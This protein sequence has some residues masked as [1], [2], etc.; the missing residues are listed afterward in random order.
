MQRGLHDRGH[1]RRRPTAR[2]IPRLPSCSWLGC[3]SALGVPEDLGPSD[4]VQRTLLTALTRSATSSAARPKPSSSPGSGRSWPTPRPPPPSAHA[5]GDRGATG[6]SRSRRPWSNPRRVS[7]P[8]WRRTGPRRAGG[9][10]RSGAPARPGRGRW[11]KLPEDQRVAVELRY[12][13]GL[14]VPEIADQMGRTTVSVTGLLYRG[15]KALREGM[16]GPTE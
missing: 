8:G 1:R 10:L 5:R 13:K 6:C 9:S 12:L 2:A 15:T 16:T 14:S 4:L 7:T 11:P 3:R